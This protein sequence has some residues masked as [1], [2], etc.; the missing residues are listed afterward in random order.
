MVVLEGEQ[1]REMFEQIKRVRNLL[2]VQEEINNKY[3]VEL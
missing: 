3:M 2:N 1:Q